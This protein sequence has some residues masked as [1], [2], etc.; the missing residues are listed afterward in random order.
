[1]PINY[2]PPAGWRPLAFAAAILLCV[3]HS[4]SGQW[5]NTNPAPGPDNPATRP[6][7]SS[8]R[9]TDNH[10]KTAPGKSSPRVSAAEDRQEKIEQAIAEGNDARNR[11]EYRQALAHYREVSEKLDPKEPR[12]FYG[13]GNVNADLYCYDSAVAAYRTALDLKMD[14]VEALVGLGY[15]YVGKERYDDA[16]GTLNKALNI[17]RNDVDTNLALGVVYALKNEYEKATEQINLVINDKLVHD[18]DRAKAYAALGDVYWIRGN[19]THW[20]WQEIIAQYEKAISTDPGLVRAYISLGSAKVSLAFEKFASVTPRNVTVEDRERL[21]ASAKEANDYI[22]KAVNEHGYSKPDADLL[23]G[24]GLMHQ[25]R[26]QDA[27]NKVNAYL[28][29]VNALKEQMS[30]PDMNVAAKCDYGFGRLLASGNWYLGFIRAEEGSLETDG[31]RRAALLDEAGNYF[32]QAIKLKEDYALA[33]NQLGLVYSTQGKYDDAVRQFNIALL[34]TK[35]ESGKAQIH[36]SIKSVYFRKGRDEDEQGKYE[37][38]IEDYT[39]AILHTTEER[40]KAVL[41]EKI[42]GAYVMLRRFDDAL[43]NVQEA[44]RRD[45][46]NPSFYE[47]LAMICVSQGDLEN[48]FKWLKKAE[49]VRTTPSTNP[50]P[51]YYLGAT[52]AIRFLRQ[53]NENDFKEAVTWLKKTVEIKRDFTLAYYALGTIYQSH[54]NPDEALASYEKAVQYDPKNPTAQMTLGL[55]YFDLKHNDEAAI[56]YLKRGIELKPDYAEAHWRLGL[57]HH[58]KK[59]DAEAVREILEAIKYDPKDLQAYLALASVYKDQKKYAE[60]VQYLKKAAGVAPKDFRPHKELAKIY[61]E[62]KRNDDAIRSYEEAINVLDAEYSWY[63]WTK[64]LYTAR[65][66]RLRG[67]YAEAVAHFQKLP[68]PPPAELPGQTLYDIALT[69]VASKDK[70]AALEQYQQLVRLKSPLAEEL[71]AKINEMK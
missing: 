46:K 26:Y 43:S 42:G 44:I 35:D 2:L 29:K 56:Q 14:Y 30:S 38:A 28:A 61:E 63:G 55:G 33:Y 54:S 37:E 27:I 70:K 69:Y 47:S 62:Q 1:M 13:I 10:T 41:N 5:V 11:Y 66:E 3:S 53:G 15:A 12:A 6:R 40:E 21:A 8:S 7:G 59:D 39:K 34:H 68:P 18:K 60:A 49:E 9:R 19:A 58:H 17:K 67:N 51:Y 50:D 52:H 23:L 71:L 65:I 64:G 20:E 25:A 31:Q 4:A 48:T 24:L 57:A 36:N 32:K 22:E 45:P 16:L